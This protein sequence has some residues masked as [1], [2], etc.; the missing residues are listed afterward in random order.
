MGG[1]Q[2]RFSMRAQV[3]D[4]LNPIMA[5][6]PTKL[7]ECVFI[8]WRANEENAL[9]REA[10]VQVAN[11]LASASPE[12]MVAAATAVVHDYIDPSDPTARRRTAAHMNKVGAVPQVLGAALTSVVRTLP[13]HVTFVL[14]LT[15]S[16][17]LSLHR[18]LTRL[19][20]CCRARSR[21]RWRLTFS[22]TTCARARWWRGR[23]AR[24]GPGWLRWRMTRWHGPR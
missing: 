15:L 20:W 21:T 12:Q 10:L 13:Y 9:V 17:S 3:M 23:R 22:P 1:M 16:L 7:L 8:A 18:G 5:A 2:V 4:A 11:R 14:I 6:A 19:C 24:C